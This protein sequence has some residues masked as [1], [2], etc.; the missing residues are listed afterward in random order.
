MGVP[1]EIRKPVYTEVN[2]GWFWGWR[3]P[4][5][6]VTWEHTTSFRSL[7]TARRYVMQ[8]QQVCPGCGKPYDTA[9]VPVSCDGHCESEVLPS[10]EFSAGNT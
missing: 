5:G 7:V 6:S 4:N 3:L 9:D 1:T 2:G 10:N 8:T